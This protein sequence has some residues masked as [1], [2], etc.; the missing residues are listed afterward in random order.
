MTTKT[1]Q[2]CGQEKPAEAFSK[3]YPNRCR[4]CVAEAARDK[5]QAKAGACAYRD[6]C[7]IYA[8]TIQSHPPR[9][10]QPSLFPEFN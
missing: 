8:K 4:E 6:K 2:I 10:F 1:C 9:P 3:S 7:P 5:R